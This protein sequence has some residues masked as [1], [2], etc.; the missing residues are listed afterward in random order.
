MYSYQIAQVLCTLERGLQCYG[1]AASHTQ[2][3]EL[4]ILFGNEGSY[5]TA[6]SKQITPVVTLNDGV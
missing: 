1:L 5:R 4:L 6:I 2:R 3:H